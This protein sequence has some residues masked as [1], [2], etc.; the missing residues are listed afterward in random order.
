MNNFI[1][2]ILVTVSLTASSL[3]F[4]AKNHFQFQITNYHT[5]RQSGQ[6]IDVYVRYAM[7]DTVDY[8]K[9]PDYRDLRNI[10]MQ[11]LEPTQQLPTN[12]FW[13]VIAA[14]LGDELMSRY[15]MA[16]VSVQLLTY[17]NPNGS[18]SEPGFHGPIYTV[19]EVIPLSQVVLPSSKRGT[20]PAG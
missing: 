20:Q 19:G 18:I 16:G 17:P 9:Y 12:T 7:K 2:I 6:T 8:S 4:A 13:E 11:Y 5:Q 10:A 3:S 15:P 1:K 14:K